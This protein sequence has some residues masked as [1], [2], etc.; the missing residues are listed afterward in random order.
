MPNLI[1]DSSSSI[2]NQ[3]VIDLKAGVQIYFDPD[4]TTDDRFRLSNGIESLDREKEA[5]LGYRSAA[6]V[7]QLPWHSPTPEQ[8]NLLISTASDPATLDPSKTIGIV[9]F[10]ATILSKITELLTWGNE[11]YGIDRLKT[12]DINQHNDYRLAIADLNNYIARTYSVDDKFFC[13][14]INR[15]EIDKLT[16]TIDWLNYLP[17]TPFVGLHLD[18]WEKLP[19]RRR[20]FSKQRICIN[21]GQETRYFLF[22]NR[23]LL[24]LVTDL[25]LQDPDYF[26]QDYR[27]VRL[28]EKFM[29]MRDR[30]PIVSLAIHPGEAYIAP[31]ENIIHDATSMSKQLPDWSLTFLGKFRLDCSHELDNK[32]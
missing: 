18:S 29:K 32:K 30:Y 8:L 15:S 24:Q 27:G 17:S 11:R 31:T 26:Y 21:L 16:T 20:H 7:P 25:N 4:I 2:L 6:F 13:L 28:A 22:V 23:T 10:S 19:L 3:S 14:G 1:F 9:K 5:D 12:T